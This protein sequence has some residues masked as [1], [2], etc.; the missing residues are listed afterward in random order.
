MRRR[1]LLASFLVVP[2]LL[3]SGCGI[4]IPPVTPDLV[5]TAQGR[6]PEITDHQ[7]EQGRALYTTRCNTCHH[8][9]DPRDEGEAEWPKY[10]AEM[11]DKAKLSQ[12]EKDLILRYL[13]AARS[14]LEKPSA[15]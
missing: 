15:K 7:L 3:I 11:G 10:V 9:H 1:H 12:G 2:A 8:L 13:L 14:E 6:W 5:R 4:V